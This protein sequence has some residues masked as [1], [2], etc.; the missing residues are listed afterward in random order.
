MLA[1]VVPA[2]IADARPPRWTTASRPTSAAAS[3]RSRSGSQP[4]AS[5]APASP[6]AGSPAPASP[7]AASP[8]A[9]RSRR[10]RTTT[11]PFARSD[12]TSADPTNPPAPPTSTR[13]ASQPTAAARVRGSAV[14]DD[15]CRDEHSRHDQAH[16]DEA[17]VALAGPQDDQ[18]HDP[19]RGGEGQDDHTDRE[20]PVAQGMFPPTSNRRTTAA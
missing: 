9:A 12:A 16:H 14:P 5:P 19:H 2:P 4:T 3:I 6:V 17:A 7:V 13:N 1:A 20:Q 18:R 11:W 8:V 10:S 15:G